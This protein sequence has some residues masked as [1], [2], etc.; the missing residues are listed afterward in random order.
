[1]EQNLR[2]REQHKRRLSWMPWLYFSL[3]EKHKIWA[4]EWQQE[5]QN[6]LRAV[7]TINIGEDCFISPE[8]MLF[9]EP[10][11][12]IVLGEG[13]SVAAQV[14]VHG[15]VKL[16]RRV[17]L[18][19]R[20]TLDGGTLGI[21]IGDDTRIATGTAIFA[22]DHGMNPARLVREQPVISRGIKIG[23]DVWIGANVGITDGVTIGDHCVVGMGSVVTRDIP[24]WSIAVGN[25][26]RVI[27]DRRTWKSPFERSQE[28]SV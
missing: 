7:E 26:A 2:Y 5:I 14:F 21:E 6:E 22:F 16:G 12:A 19:A 3:K 11:R 9:A 17:S 23:N 27:A 4:R 8:A 10:G 28:G 18:N 15:P 25:P 1:M 20:V 13:C 24:P